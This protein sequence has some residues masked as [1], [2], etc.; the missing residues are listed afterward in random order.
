MMFAILDEHHRMKKDAPSG[1]A[2]ALGE[3]VLAGNAGSKEPAYAAI[4]VGHIVGEHEVTFAGEGE[5][6]RIRHSVTDR[7]IFARGAL[8]AA[9]WLNGKPKGFYG[10]QH[11]LSL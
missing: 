1:T 4:R 5:V 11:V 9:L 8:Q 7:R 3:V 10:M 6:I 2:K